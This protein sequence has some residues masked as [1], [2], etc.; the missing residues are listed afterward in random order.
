MAGLVVHIVHV[1]LIVSACV[2]VVGGN[3]TVV[4]AVCVHVCID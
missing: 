2:L 1:Y 4:A 3:V